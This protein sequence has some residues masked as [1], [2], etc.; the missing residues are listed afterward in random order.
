LRTPAEGCKPG[1]VA[2]KKN[3]LL[4]GIPSVDIT[5]AVKQDRIVFWHVNQK[6][7]C[8]AAAEDMYKNLGKALRK[9]CG[10]KRKY[11]VIED[12]DPK[13]FQ[14]GKGIAEKVKQKIESMKL[15]V[16]SPEWMP[17]DFCLWHEIEERLYAKAPNYDETKKQFLKRLRSIALRLPRQMVRK[18][19]LSMRKR[20]HMTIEAKGDH[21]RID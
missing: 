14:S 18:C 12:G 21:I 9:T 19:L 16:R 3:R 1:C 7:W 10:N 20:I 11:R 2:P 13:G 4:L 15:P 5:A 8:G 17:L 6:P